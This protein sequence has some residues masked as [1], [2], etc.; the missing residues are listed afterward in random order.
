[1]ALDNW[2]GL[3]MNFNLIN[4]ISLLLECRTIKSHFYRISF[5]SLFWVLSGVVNAQTILSYETGGDYYFTI[6]LGV[7]TI[8]VECWG[9]GGGGGRSASPNRGRGGGGGGAFAKKT[10]SVTPCQTY[11]IRVGKGG[12]GTAGPNHGGDSFFGDS[13]V[14]AKG[15]SGVANNSDIAGLGG[16]SSLCIGDIVFSGGNGANGNSGVSG[17]GGGG[18]GTVSVGGNA[19]GINAGIGGGLLGGNGG[20]GRS[21]YGSSSPGISIGGGGAGGRVGAIQGDS[22]NGGI[23]ADG[24]VKISY[25]VPNACNAMPS[26]GLISG[27]NQNGCNAD[28]LLLFSSCYSINPGVLFQ[29]E[30]SMNNGLTWQSVVGENNPAQCRIPVFQSA[31]FRLMAVCLATQD[32]AFSNIFSYIVT[33]CVS[34]PPV[35]QTMNACNVHFYDSGGINANYGN[36]Q[37][38]SIT[39]CSDSM[40]VRVDFSVFNLDIADFL[41]VYDGSNTSATLIY[42]LTGQISGN[43]IPPIITSAGQ[44][45]TFRFVSNSSI[46][47]IGW[48][49]FV[50]CTNTP[51]TVARNFCEGAALICDLNG[52]TGK[53]SSFYLPNKPGNLCDYCSLFSG[54]LDNN[55]WISFIASDT[56]AEFDIS[57]SNCSSLKGIQLA[58][59]SAQNCQNFNLISNPIHTSGASVTNILQNNSTTSIVVPYGNG[60]NLIPGQ[61]YYVMVDGW[62][63]DVCDYSI[64]AQTGIFVASINVEDT[65]I[66]AGESVE[67][68]AYGGSSENDYLWSNGHIGSSIIVTPQSDTVYYVTISG[69]NPMCL[70]SYILSS[71]IQVVPNVIAS[72]NILDTIVCMGQTVDLIAYG[73]SLYQWSTG[74]TS[75]NISLSLWS[76]TSVFV[77]VSNGLGCSMVLESNIVASSNLMPI[78]NIPTTYC[79]GDNAPSLPMISEN[80]IAGQWHP[81]AINTNLSGVTNYV[82][83]P[84]QNQCSSLYEIEI[85]VEDGIVPVFSSFGPYCQ[86]QMVPLLPNISQNNIQGS[87]SPAIV[88]TSQIGNTSYVF[89]P[90]AN[91][92]ASEVVVQIVVQS[93]IDPIFSGIGPFCQNVAAPSL[94]LVSDNNIPGSWSPSAINTSQVGTS[95]YLFQP[96][97]TV[98]ANSK[99]LS[100]EVVQVVV[101]NVQ[102]SDNHFCI[103]DSSIVLIATPS[104]GFWSGSGINA[105]S[106]NVFNPDLAGIG[107][108]TLTYQLNS[109]CSYPASTVVYVNDVP[110]VDILGSHQQGFCQGISLVLNG[111]SNSSMLWS[112]GQNTTSINVNQPGIYYLIS[113]NNCGQSMDSVVVIMYDSP[114]FSLGN[115]TSLCLSVPFEI[116]VN[117]DFSSYLWSDGSTRSSIKISEGGRYSVVVTD[118]NGC[119]AASQIKIVN[120]CEFFVWIPNAF[121]PNGDGINDGFGPVLSGVSEENYCFVI[122]NRWGEKVFETNRI[123]EKWDG[124]Y[125]NT[126]EIRYNNVFVYHLRLQTEIGKEYRYNGKVVLIYSTE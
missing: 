112:T 37:D 114:H 108:H 26:A 102:Q 52:Y 65:T 61:M 43:D 92:C 30:M 71:Q 78:F 59:Y 32:T 126:N 70:N 76:D 111:V 110:T 25:V 45:L 6:P 35:H 51:N 100:V 66:C 101:P 75:S 88:N 21:T 1:M 20:Q 17:G 38:R 107:S 57:V 48:E 77:T 27:N 113:S 49:A 82:F 33:P 40:F 39:F 104:G 4:M 22:R 31:F 99:Q 87:W 7:D 120:D 15:G 121:S 3:F 64:Q 42:Q 10:I 116:V 86:N 122:Y 98:C 96:N 79:P 63:G 115:D 81:S 16:L 83:T 53:T 109:S 103:N 68:I 106:P 56:I 19:N 97:S 36:N 84:N 95:N 69:G 123:H 74:Q 89:T 29:W 14:L 124:K 44:C 9:A 11:L 125:L 2:Q 54:S 5:F 50:S 62:D 117:D 12:L 41:Y 28:T 105:N 55:S 58:V 24:A 46:N 67:L 47:T 34:M 94:P 23:G 118:A 73:G 93:N 8:T 80:G 72:I 85:N 13:L 60:A 91:Q 18:A 119:T 90:E